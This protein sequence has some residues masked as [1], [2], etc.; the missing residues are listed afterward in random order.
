MT[1]DPGALQRKVRQLDNDMQ[2]TYEMLT[3]ISAQQR[4]MNTRL[5]TLETRVEAMDTRLESVELK[6]D[7]L[8]GKVDALEL[9][10]DALGGKVDTL[11][12]QMGEVLGILR[13]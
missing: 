9:K 7:A 8:D 4:R 1:L 10:V 12:T 13:G 6:V 5:G 11:G 2:A 3:D